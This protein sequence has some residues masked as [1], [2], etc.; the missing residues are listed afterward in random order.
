MTTYDTEHSARE[1]FGALL[2][3][4]NAEV[5]QISCEIESGILVVTLENQDRIPVNPQCRFALSFYRYQLVELAR[6]ILRELDPT[7]ED[8]ILATL[9]RLE[10]KLPD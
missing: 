1:E 9:K 3:V 4:I 7:T 2:R 10:E 6:A 5:G 8:E